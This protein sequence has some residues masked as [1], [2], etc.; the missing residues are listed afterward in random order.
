[1][2]NINAQSQIYAEGRKERRMTDWICKEVHTD[3]G[4]YFE[5]VKELIRCKDCW[6]WH[7]E[8]QHGCTHD[9]EADDYCSKG[10]REEE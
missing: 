6:C 4:G 7:E 8:E 5:P 10:S 3:N 1:M 9:T 2:Q